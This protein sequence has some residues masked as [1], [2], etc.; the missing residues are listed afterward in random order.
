MDNG[1]HFLKNSLMKKKEYIHRCFV[2]LKNRNHSPFS[3]IYIYLLKYNNRTVANSRSYFWLFLVLNV[4]HTFNLPLF[5]TIFSILT[6]CHFAKCL[7]YVI[8]I[9]DCY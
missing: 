2:A 1:I 3:S 6:S 9:S 8:V 5:K 7:L 4:N